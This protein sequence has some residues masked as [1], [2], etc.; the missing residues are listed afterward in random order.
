MTAVG[1]GTMAIPLI[2][3]NHTQIERLQKPD[4]RPRSPMTGEPLRA[5]DLIPLSLMVDPE[6]TVGEREGRENHG[7]LVNDLNN[8][9]N[10]C[11]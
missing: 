8:G 6:W 2:D 7:M 1:S 5:K 3:P 10:V 11:N 4:K 9:Y